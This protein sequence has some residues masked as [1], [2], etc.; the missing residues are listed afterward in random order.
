MT[1]S[2]TS[3]DVTNVDAVVIGAGFAGLY[4]LHRLRDMLGLSVRAYERGDGVGGTWYWNRYPG[5]RCDSEAYI[6]CYSFDKDLLQ[7]WEWSG[8]YPEQPE[9]LRYLNHVA[10]RFDLRRDIQF[11]TR[12]TAA[13]FNET[14]N[15]WEIET[16]QGD[17]VTAQ[18]LITGIGCLSAGQIPQIPGLDT[19]KGEWYH[20]GAWPHEGVDLAGKRVGVIGTGSSGVQSIPVIAQ[21]AGHLYV[22]QRTPQYTIP[23]RHHNVDRAY[24]QEIKSRYDEIWEKAKTSAVG[25]P[26]EP[27]DRSALEVSDEER[28]A[29][30]EAGWEQGGFQF[31]FASF[32]DIGVDLRANATASEFIRSKI[33]EIVKDPE[34]AEKLVPVDHPFTSKRALID[35]DYFETYNRPNVTLVDIRHAP[36]QAITPKGIRTEDEEYELDVI[37][38]ATGFDAMTGAFNRIDIRG[39][40]G[41]ALKDKWAAGP[42]TYLGL[43]SAGFP[44][45]LMITGP[46][47]PSVLSNMPVSIEQHV[48]WISRLVEDMRERGVDVVEADPQA[49]EAWVAHVN[50]VAEQTLFMLADSWYLGANIPGKPRVFMPYPGGVGVYRE[51]CDEVRANGYEGFILGAGSREPAAVR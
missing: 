17:R 45:L 49:E 21:Q 13:H 50:E 4:M 37:V 25:F 47:S 15:R 36:I 38:F 11:N 32:K 24:L 28:R 22:F 46:G 27:V 35:T 39:R 40:G 19:F 12:V 10:D 30:F 3:T 29:I 26:A 20:T 44:N 14:T 42:K 7:E 9:I 43:A 8:K 5:A 2:A 31:A 16:D 51:K 41:E 18:Y 1:D 6:Y 34:T 23:A 33:R 48:E